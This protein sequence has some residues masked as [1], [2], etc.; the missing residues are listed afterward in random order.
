MYLTNFIQEKKQYLPIQSFSY[1]RDAVLYPECILLDSSNS[2]WHHNK[3][4]FGNF[5]TTVVSFVDL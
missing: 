5:Y 3:I 2:L 1:C 4:P